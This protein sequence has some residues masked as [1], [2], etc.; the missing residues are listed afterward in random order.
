V[1]GTAE[2]TKDH[3]R[4]TRIKEKREKQDIFRNFSSFKRQ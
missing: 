4:E 2:R 1:E 3:G